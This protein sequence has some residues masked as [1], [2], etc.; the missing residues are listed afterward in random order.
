MY[1]LI[2]AAGFQADSSEWLG[3]A[4]RDAAA[5]HITA[6]AVES[7]IDRVLRRKES[8][9]NPSARL[10]FQKGLRILRERLLVGDEQTKTSDATIGVV[11]KL[12]SAAHFDGDFQT[13]KDHMRGI[14]NMVDLRGGLEAFKNT[15]LLIDMLR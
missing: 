12:A 4:G 14:R 15:R 13:A 8:T 1:P 6:F 10:H 9:I 3:L 11:L 2:T 5:L 7:F